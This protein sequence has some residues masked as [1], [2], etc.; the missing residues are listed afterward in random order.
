M[1]SVVDK[2]RKLTSTSSLPEV[3]AEPKADQWMINDLYNEVTPKSLPQGGMQNGD[4]YAVVNKGKV[5]PPVAKKPMSRSQTTSSKIEVQED[6]ISRDSG[7]DEEEPSIPD[8]LYGDEDTQ[9]LEPPPLPPRLYSLS[10]FESEDEL[11][12]DDIMSADEDLSGGDSRAFNSISNP[13]YE[14]SSSI[15]IAL[16]A[17]SQRDQKREEANPLYQTMAE[18]RKEVM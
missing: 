14:S 17:A 18:L 1:Y 9:E 3:Y 7:V 6:T 16:S 2:T 4:I 13:T 8:R 5:P 11:C 10:D 12:F 15:Q